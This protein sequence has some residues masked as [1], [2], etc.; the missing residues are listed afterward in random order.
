MPDNAEQLGRL[1]DALAN[2]Y[3][4]ERELGERRGDRGRELLRGVE[5]EDGELACLTI[6]ST[7]SAPR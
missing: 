6:P 3:S 2:R 5:G 4:I 1:K 7:G